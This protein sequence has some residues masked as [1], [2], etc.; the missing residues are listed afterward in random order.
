MTLA[1]RCSEC[2]LAFGSRTNR[3]YCCNKI[4]SVCDKCSSKPCKECKQPRRNALKVSKCSY[5]NCKQLYAEDD[6]FF[7]FKGPYYI[8]PK[9]MARNYSFFYSKALKDKKVPLDVRLNTKST[10]PYQDLVIYF[11]QWCFCCANRIGNDDAF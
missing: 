8:C 2:K 4:K 5:I 6:M 9:C 11:K 3:Y 7:D 1:Q 10:Y